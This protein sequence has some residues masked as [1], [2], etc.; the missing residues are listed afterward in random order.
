[1][2]T[3]EYL[4]QYLA[5]FFF[6]WEIFHTIIKTHILCS[7]T[8]FQKILPFIRWCGKY[9][10]VSQATNDN[11]ILHM[12]FAHQITKVTDTRHTFLCFCMATLVVQT[13]LTV[14]FMHT[15][16]VPC[17]IVISARVINILRKGRL[18]CLNVRSRGL[19]FRYRASCK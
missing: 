17:W 2:N 14:M 5:E 15:L 10:R 6:E 3:Y 1:M 9:G 18:N 7:V 12:H 19:T 8:I 16:P 4:W 13:H 11:I